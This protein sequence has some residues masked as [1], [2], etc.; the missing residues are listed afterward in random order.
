MITYEELREKVKNL[1][2]F[3]GC[4]NI[5]RPPVVN[6]GFPGQF[7]YSFTEQPWLN[8][9]G[10]YNDFNHDYVFSA[11]PVCIRYNDIFDEK[12]KTSKL[13]DRDSWKYLGV[14]EMADLAGQASLAGTRDILELQKKQAQ[15]LVSLLLSLRITKEQIFPTYQ[16]EAHVSEAT[17]KRYNFDFIIPE[18][19]VGKQVFLET[20]VPEK[21]ITFDSS[22]KCTLALNLYRRLKSG[23]QERVLSPWG[24][25]TKLMLILEQEK[26]PDLWI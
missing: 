6:D 5:A 18:D 1:E 15:N 11:I 16:P 17:N 14:F 7:N 25:R 20:G 13:E 24:Y 2:K 26:I 9:Y 8:E 23:G 19:K 10:R 3:P 12:T 4:V 22:G 21:N